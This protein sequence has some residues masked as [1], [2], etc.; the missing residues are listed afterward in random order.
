[1]QENTLSSQLP[2]QGAHCHIPPSG[3]HR[4]IPRDASRATRHLQEESHGDFQSE[5]RILLLKHIPSTKA[6][7]SGCTAVPAPEHSLP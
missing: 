4:E 3:G 1:M 6:V 2:P 7:V 5:P